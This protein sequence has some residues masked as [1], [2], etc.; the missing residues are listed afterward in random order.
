MPRSA[1]ECHGLPLLSAT[2]CHRCAAERK[3]VEKALRLLFTSGDI[4]A[5][6][7]YVLRQCDKLQCG[8]ASLLDLVFANEVRL[9]TSDDV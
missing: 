5:V 3:I 6:K 7:A 1:T 8:R 4:S 2:D 9:M